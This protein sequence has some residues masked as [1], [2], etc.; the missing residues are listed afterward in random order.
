MQRRPCLKEDGR[1]TRSKRDEEDYDGRGDDN[2]GG[3]GG[4]N[5]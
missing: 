5:R 2:R 4:G 3:V 1:E